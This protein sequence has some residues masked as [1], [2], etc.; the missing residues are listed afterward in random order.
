MCT[1]LKF[2]P[3]VEFK[4]GKRKLDFAFR[5]P[6]LNIYDKHFTLENYYAFRL[7]LIG[8]KIYISKYQQVARVVDVVPVPCGHCVECLKARSE[9]WS[10]RL[11]CEYESLRKLDSYVAAFCTFTYND[12]HLPFSNSLKK[13]D[14]QDFLKRLRYF[15][16]QEFNATLKYFLAGEYGS[17]TGRPHFHAIFF[18]S[19]M[20]NM[21][22]FNELL[23]R[24]WNKGFVQCSFDVNFK[25]CA[26]V[27]RYVD[28]KCDENMKKKDFLDLK[29]EPPFLLC[30]KHLGLNYL[31]DNYDFISKYGY[32]PLADGKRVS[33]PKYYSDYMMNKFDDY[34]VKNKSLKHT[35]ESIID[36]FN[37][38]VY[39][40]MT[41]GSY[42][43]QKG[44]SQSK[45]KFD[46][47][48][49]GL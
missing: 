23:E 43:E 6:A 3:L 37:H 19:G 24:A 15:L 28:K 34:S 22:K 17:R 47:L 9:S 27:A 29:L 20:S 26:Y 36:N 10:C 21:R 7:S 18:C 31:L 11:V 14:C 40:G 42:F 2:L 46:V 5:S 45:F 1:S 39:L 35:K 48:K 8:S 44:A 4:D 49:R 12:L 30:S 32:I 33:V 25:S 16:D 38:A 13:K 41:L